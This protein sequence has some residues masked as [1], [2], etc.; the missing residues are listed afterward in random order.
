MKTLG[1]KSRKG[2]ETNARAAL[3]VKS[4]ETGQCRAVC[5][6]RKNYEVPKS[7]QKFREYKTKKHV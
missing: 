3:S 7:P 1:K 6:L 2:A 4:G 5:N